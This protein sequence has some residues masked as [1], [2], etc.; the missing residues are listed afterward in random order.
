MRYTFRK[1]ASISAALTA[2]STQE[3]V[4]SP[5]RC[6]AISRSRAIPL[7]FFFSRFF[8]SFFFSM[9]TRPFPKASPKHRGELQLTNSNALF[10]NVPILRNM[11]KRE[12]NMADRE[13][14][15]H[16]FFIL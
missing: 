14:V 5:R 1:G 15:G 4:T 8:F 2:E 16:C 3:S 13:R 9:K 11:T 7:L 12:Q 6:P 10:Y